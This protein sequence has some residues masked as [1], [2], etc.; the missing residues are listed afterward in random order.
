MTEEEKIAAKAARDAAIA[1]LPEEDRKKLEEADT[2]KS[3]FTSVV[4]ELKTERVKKQTA[5]AERDTY[6]AKVDNKTDTGADDV[7]TKVR[8]IL[9]EKERA[10]AL[11]A[12][13]TAEQKF[14]SAHKEFDESNDPGGIKYAA[15]Q[16]KLK[17]FSTDG[18]VS[19]TEYLDVYADAYKLLTGKPAEQIQYNPYASTPSQNGANLKEGD[20]NPLSDKEERL[21]KQQGWTKERYLAQKAKRPSYVASLLNL[22]D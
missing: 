14:K 17:R 16:E 15:F 12:K 20:K 1:A 10:N 4:E 2:Y 19:E 8:N 13:Q 5:E 22:V 11:T 18:L 3:Q 21:I 9:A 6:K 7:E